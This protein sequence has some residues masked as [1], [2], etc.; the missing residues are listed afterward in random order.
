MGQTCIQSASCN[1]CVRLSSRGGAFVQASAFT[2]SRR[3]RSFAPLLLRLHCKS[4]MR[5][6]NAW[7]KH[8]VHQRC[9]CFLSNRA[10]EY[11]ISRFFLLSPRQSFHHGLKPF[12]PPLSRWCHPLESVRSERTLNSSTFFDRA[13]S[14]D[15]SFSSYRKSLHLTGS[16]LCGCDSMDL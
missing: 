3:V 9:F 10:K 8:R 14:L 4:W 11:T 1:V 15:R 16:K 2:V 13:R 5:T 6:M 7:W 12:A